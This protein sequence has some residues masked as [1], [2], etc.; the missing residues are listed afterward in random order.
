MQTHVHHL[1]VAPS[2]PLSTADLTLELQ[3]DR[4]LWSSCL[5]TQPSKQKSSFSK[6]KAWQSRARRCFKSGANQ[7]LIFTSK[8][9]TPVHM[10]VNALGRR[11][12]TNPH[13][14]QAHFHLAEQSSSWRLVH[15]KSVQPIESFMYRYHVTYSV[16]KGGT[17]AKRR[18]PNIWTPAKIHIIEINAFNQMGTNTQSVVNT[19]WPNVKLE[20]EQVQL[21]KNMLVQTERW[22]YRNTQEGSTQHPCW[23]S[24][25]RLLRSNE[26]LFSRGDRGQRSREP[27]HMPR[28]ANRDRGLIQSQLITL[29][30]CLTLWGRLIDLHE[31][32]RHE[33][34]FEKHIWL[35]NT[36]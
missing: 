15:M 20:N 4:D 16:V 5:D 12:H 33:N 1:A 7:T 34:T 8:L 30:P 27:K 32:L 28:V 10:N 25:T 13:V 26:T 31:C 35:I 21:E 3:N 17:K 22:A 11:T 36:S 24:W 19:M 29:K 6:Q 14:W 9:H 23:Q 18:F 2:T